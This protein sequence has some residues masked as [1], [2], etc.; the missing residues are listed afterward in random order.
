TSEQ[1]TSFHGIAGKALSVGRRATASV[2]KARMPVMRAS[3]SLLAVL[4]FAAPALRAQVVNDGATNTLS[5]VTNTFTGDVT[6]GTNTSFTLL[7]L[8]NNSLLT[9]SANGVISRNAT[10]TSNQVHLVSPSA[11]W[12]MNG[13]LFVGS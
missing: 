5:N 9:N 7:I 8:S 1:N 2:P 11:R 12:L 4:A 3:L 6:V 13:N 10:A